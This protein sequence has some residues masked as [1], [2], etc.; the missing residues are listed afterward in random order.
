V[1]GLWSRLRAA[2]DS[3]SE[4]ER[5]LVASAGS[6]L[7]LGLLYV[8]VV[9]PALSFG[10]RAEDGLAAAKQQL[11]VVVRLRREYDDV[12][13]RLDSVERR[14]AR[15]TAGSLGTKLENLAQQSLVK[16]ESIQPQSSPS[17]E[18]YREKKVEVDLKGVSLPQTVSYLGRIESDAQVLSIKA[19]RIRIR[20]EK[21]ELL[22]VTF[23]VSSFERI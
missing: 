14:I 9:N 21:P 20:P 2:F 11:A 6:L 7:G 16:I 18:Q 10:S 1:S 8:V 15:G 19:L 3:L 5:I 17:N 4:R 12:R 23:T 22:D 13:G